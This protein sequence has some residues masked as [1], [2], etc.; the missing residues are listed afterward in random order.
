MLLQL[1]Q[2]TG[3]QQVKQAAARHVSLAAVPAAAEAKAP[4]HMTPNQRLRQKLLERIQHIE[5]RMD[6]R[7]HEA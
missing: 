6:Q 1:S 5:S 4:Q 2:V 3:S 7:L